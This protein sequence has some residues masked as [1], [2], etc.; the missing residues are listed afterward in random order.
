MVR[1][2]CVCEG[3]CVVW[4]VRRSVLWVLCECGYTV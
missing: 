3:S 4:G 2:E 1:G